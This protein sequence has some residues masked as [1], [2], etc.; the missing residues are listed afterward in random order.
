MRISYYAA[1]FASAGFRS[2]MRVD[3][4]SYDAN[5]YCFTV[6]LEV[7]LDSPLAQGK[8]RAYAFL[9]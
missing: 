9:I 4:W 1:A 3:A 2:I 6:S 8:L 7:F 5:D